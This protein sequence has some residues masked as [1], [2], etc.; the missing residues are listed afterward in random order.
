MPLAVPHLPMN[1]YIA[2]SNPPE[3]IR[4]H[5]DNLLHLLDGLLRLYPEALSESEAVLSKLAAEYH[6]YGKTIYLFQ[7]NV[8]EKACLPFNRI[9]ALDTLY[10]NFDSIPH[11]YLSPAFLPLMEL[12]KT[13]GN[14]GLWALVNSIYYHHVRPAVANSE[15]KQILEADL[16]PRLGDRYSLNTAYLTLIQSPENPPKMQQWLLYAVVKGTLNRLDYAASAGETF[17]EASRLQDGLSF[18]EFVERKLKA[19]FPLRP[20]QEY[21]KANREKNLVVVASTGVGK[22]EAACLW[23]AGKKL[24][25][26]LPLKVSINAI[27]K[28][29]HGT[30]PSEYGFKNCALLHSDALSILLKSEDETDNPLEKYDKT[31]LFSY[32][33]TVC[34][35]DQL[36][37]FVYRYLGCEII[38]SVLKY[39]CVVIDEIQAYSPDIAAKL[40]VGLEMI[41]ALGGKFAIITATM[42]P[43]L[44]DAMKR[45]GIPYE[46][47]A[48]FFSPLSRHV[49]HYSKSD[50]DFEQIAQAGLTS[51]VLV[52]C[53]TVKRACQVYQALKDG[54][55]V[56][57]LHA[58]FKQCHRRRL[59]NDIMY[60]SENCIA[61]IW[62]TTQIVEA[63]LDIDFD[64]LFTE[65]CP[66][67]SLLQRLGRCRRKREYTEASPN[68]FISDT[69]SGAGTVYDAEIYA[70]SVER[71]QPFCGRIF[72]EGEKNAYVCSVYDTAELKSTKYYRDFSDTVNR[73]TAIPPQIFSA[74]EAK[75]KFRDI[76][77]VSV[78]DDADYN[79]M[80][81][82]GE[83]GAL[84]E[85]MNSSDRKIRT[86]AR[87]EFLDHTVTINPMRSGKA[88]PDMSAP[89]FI[90]NRSTAYPLVYRTSAKYDYDE[91]TGRGLGLILTPDGSEM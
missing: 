31:R 42:P 61:G 40:I 70:R 79:R 11:G 81:S 87:Q 83:L 7:R 26:T 62:V 20:A 86:E 57:L 55:D 76:S 14:E 89:V 50:F 77:S 15:I 65:M 19:R 88:K 59:E 38:P 82:T 22:T 91:R 67:D 44:E 35:V 74:E 75:R 29:F 33:V 53:N 18:G 9:Q 4:Q 51:K 24:F 41:T 54:Y 68:V 85:A 17:L 21:M 8:S 5:T 49:L 43:F 28:R 90:A 56:R 52:I 66:A 39:S 78:I 48:P 37:T 13:L 6:D 12:R 2:K 73:M 30:G 47:P 3:S 58:H 71:L 27:Y 10:K 25:Y 84:T 36:F 69:G 63:S 45:R 23:A 32:P 1:M 64:Y 80:L 72:T 46:K 60:F 16:R 34:T